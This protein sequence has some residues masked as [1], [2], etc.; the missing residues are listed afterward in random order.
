[1]HINC[2][3]H[4]NCHPHVFIIDVQETTEA[5]LAN[6]GCQEKKALTFFYIIKTIH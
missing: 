4:L 1:M 3:I 6:C 2:F 5:L